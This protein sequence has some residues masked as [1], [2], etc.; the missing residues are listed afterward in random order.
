MLW[1][2]GPTCPS[3]KK[4]NKEAEQFGTLTHFQFGASI[5]VTTSFEG[6]VGYKTLHDEGHVDAKAYGCDFGSIWL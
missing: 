5:M 3:E 6:L 1:H 4:L 2:H